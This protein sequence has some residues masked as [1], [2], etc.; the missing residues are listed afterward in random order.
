MRKK[1]VIMVVMLM[2][3]SSIACI[4]AA[5]ELTTDV[6]TGAEV[7]A[8][9]NIIELPPAFQRDL[10][11]H[12]T[13]PDSWL[14]GF[15]KFFEGVDLFFTSDDVAKA[16]K[17][18][19]LAELR[20]AE[21]KEMAEN[22]KPEFVDDLVKEYKNNLEQSNKIAEVAQQVGKNITKVTELVAI[23]TSIHL[24]VLEEV[25]QKVPEQAKPSIQKA[26]NASKKG[27]EE[28]LNTLEKVQPETAA[29]IHFRIAEQRLL[30][31][32]EKAHENE[33][34]V[35]EGLVA[36]YEER[37]NKSSEIVEAAKALGKDT[38][39]IEQIV[40]EATYKHIEVLSDIYERVPEQARL[41]IEKSLNV[42][43]TGWETAVE[44]LKEKGALESIS[45]DVP[46][47]E[48]I[49]EM[50]PSIAKGEN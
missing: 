38:T 14:Y 50:M 25:L 16:E 5:S 45:E 6:T 37:I 22:G 13:T 7:D 18:A 36:D 17:H 44:A 24:D 15:K 4:S 11:P 2:N 49:E 19:Y 33:S 9:E 40:A 48:E 46:T 1:F 21:A 23:A 27:N 41:A 39:D 30:K 31:A 8:M 32:Q 3:L 35:V 12:G 26:I 47:M 10:L 28:A 20:L 29:E 34:E 42:S 43:L